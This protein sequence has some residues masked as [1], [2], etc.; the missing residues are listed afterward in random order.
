VDNDK[1]GYLT[2]AEF[3]S[4][5][6]ILKRQPEI[7][8]L[9]RSLTN[10][11]P[12]DEKRFR[13]FLLE[14]QKSHLNDSDIKRIYLDLLRHDANEYSSA[15]ST[16]T[17]SFDSNAIATESEPENLLAE[18]EATGLTL[19]QFTSYLSSPT[20]AALSPSQRKVCQDM[21]RPLPDYFISS[22]H[23]TYLIGHQWKGESTVE[24]YVR[25]LL[26]GCRSVESEQ[27]LVVPNRHVFGL[28]KLGASVDIYDGDDEPI[29]YH[30]KTLT[31]SVSVRAV[32]V[33][34]AS[35]AF[36]ASPYPIIISAEMHCGP[37]QQIKLVDILKE[38]FADQLVTAELNKAQGT[39]EEI[40]VK[41]L[42]SPEQLK[43][44][45][46]FKVIF[47]V[48]LVCLALTYPIGVGSRRGHWISRTA[49]T[50]MDL[51]YRQSP[52]QTNRL[53]VPSLTIR[54]VSSFVKTRPKEMLTVIL[55]FLD[56]TKSAGQGLLRQ[57]GIKS[58]T[59]DCISTKFASRC[60]GTRSSP[61]P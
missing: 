11:G 19:D 31:G 14:V 13:L 56:S 40:E 26:A 57:G 52:T 17:T 54:C 16:G 44:R 37:E 27:I 49:A 60:Y 6:K 45:I 30:G 38:V 3:T 47:P 58:R 20:N 25:A 4:L 15:G 51:A 9:Y 50:Q 36:M 43:Y 46:L 35:Y 7:E 61:F 29:V 8:E 32:C 59:A 55:A 41:E 23:N 12:L 18:E 33:A 28:T 53:R 10:Q 39:V 34:I 21:S 24:G 48:H 2:V 5:I 22:S 42:P 1:T